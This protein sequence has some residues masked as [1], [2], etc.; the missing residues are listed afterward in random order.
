MSVYY[1][2]AKANNRYMKGCDKNEE[3]SY[4]QYWDVNN[5]YDWAMS[6]NLPVKNSEWTKDIFQF[7]ESFIKSYNEESDKE[8]FFENDVQYTEK[9][10][11][12]HVD[13]P[14]LPERMEIE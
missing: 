1:R 11:E 9:I 4:L 2:Y 14:F 3:L 6:Q 12:L 8:H 7:N 5:L 10:H 13:L